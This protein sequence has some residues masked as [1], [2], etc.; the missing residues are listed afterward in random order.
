MVDTA[1]DDEEV[2]AL[3]HQTVLD[4]NSEDEDVTLDFSPGAASEQDAE[5]TRRT[6]R[7]FAQQCGLKR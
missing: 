4:L 3:G 7:A 5:A 2:E 6:L 1:V